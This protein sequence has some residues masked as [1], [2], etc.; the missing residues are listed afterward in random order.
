MSRGIVIIGGG[1]SAARAAFEIRRLEYSGQVTLLAS[2]PYLPYERPPLSKAFI[3]EPRPAAPEVAPARAYVRAKI[4]VLMATSAVSIDRKS[5][6]VELS[7]GQIVTYDRLLLA[8][9]A[10]PRPL[11]IAGYSRTRRVAYLRSLDDAIRIRQAIYPGSRL[12]IVGGGFIGLELAA[13]ATRRGV[14][15]TVVETL[16][17]LLSRSVPDPLAEIVAARHRTEGVQ[18]LCNETP[19]KVRADGADAQLLLAGGRTIS[20]D[21]I[22][23][24]IGVLPATSLA[25]RANLYVDNG[26]VVDDYLATEDPA[27]FAAGD[28][29]SFPVTH[30]GNK[31][32][33]LESWRN[34][35]DQGVVAA[36]NLLGAKERIVSMPWF[37]SEHYDLTLEIAGLPAEGSIYIRRDLPGEAFILFHLDESGRLVAASGIGAGTAV[38][39]GIKLAMRLIAERIH[40]AASA[41]ANPEFPLKRLL[42]ASVDKSGT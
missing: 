2:E 4:D 11:E 33:R 22:V 5:Q 30:Y 6:A 13:S 26:I 18:I 8:T 35:V 7:S 28:C 20:A 24:G 37:W 12:A 36:R 31:R 25:E 19:V 21:L 9:G 42:Q 38:S 10:V 27:I 40:P 41:L 32:F 34:A 16:P 23:V 15:V 39:K 1:E 3:Y 29:C 17:R 14:H